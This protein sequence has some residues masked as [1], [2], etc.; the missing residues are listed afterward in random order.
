MEGWLS[1]EVQSQRQD[2]LG[3]FT[4]LPRSLFDTVRNFTGF[5]DRHAR[6][7]TGAFSPAALAVAR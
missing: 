5:G 1:G 2:G 4:E 3:V 6:A 7:E